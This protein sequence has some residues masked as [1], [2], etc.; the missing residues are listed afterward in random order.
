MKEAAAVNVVTVVTPMVDVT[1]KAVGPMDWFVPPVTTGVGAPPK[2]L[3]GRT[4]SALPTV[5]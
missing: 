1:F 2:P 5:V 3:R 4:T